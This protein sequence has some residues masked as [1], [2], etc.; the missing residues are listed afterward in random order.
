MEIGPQRRLDK[1]AR[2]VVIH[3]AW[4]AP[5][6][7][8]L[9]LFF[10]HNFAGF[11]R[12]EAMDTA[13]AARNISDGRGFS[14][15]FIR[16]LSLASQPI[17]ERM[18]DLCQPPLPPLLLGLVFTVFPAADS[19]VA[20]VS[21]FFFFLTVLL[22][23]VWARQ[24]FGLN[25]AI[26]SA[27]LLALNL[28]L[29]EITLFGA[30]VS[31]GAFLL[32]LLLF[33]SFRHSGNPKS[34]F[35]IGLLFGLSFL[36]EY[37]SLLLLP[38]LLWLLIAT[39]RERR[40]SH[41]G[42]FLLGSFL[43][44]APWAIRNYRLTGLP[45]SSLRWYSLAMFG[46]TYPGSSL[47]REI[48]PPEGGLLAFIF[49][50]P[51]EMAKKSLWALRSLY[52]SLPIVCGLYVVPFFI[53]GMLQPLE[54]ARLRNLRKC[55]YAALLLIAIG[56]A[57]TTGAAEWLSP[58]VPLVVIF[59]AFSFEK[60]LA[61][62]GL[63]ERRRILARAL[64][65]VAAALPLITNLLLPTARPVPRRGNLQQLAR[66]LPR[67]TLVATD[68]PWA[69]A[70]YANRT[71]VWL[72]NAPVKQGNQVI[73]PT[74]TE[75]FRALDGPKHRIGAIFLSSHLASLP[76]GEG[77][78]GWQGLRTAPR[79]FRLEAVLDGGE[80]LLTRDNKPVGNEGK[81]E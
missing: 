56:S 42:A 54:E 80:V 73:D 19:T 29:L 21:C 33:L 58:L 48:V 7:I 3:L 41:L 36:T 5:A 75:G 46:N 39:L 23:F 44:L 74:Q 26:L 22:A 71:A 31:L 79:G 51:G 64:L 1:A 25:V 62:A 17:A 15:D 34:S 45:W 11:Y 37:A 78:A 24:L 67:E 16:P 27:L 63:G 2:Q 72:P 12:A 43:V 28:A 32:T 69:V 8:L 10:Q 13:Q 20:L 14:T 81:G 47:L 55:L 77:L 52:T 60:L 18:P 59:S 70:W 61:S 6:L 40:W 30:L 38:A 76:A 57:V 49:S 50:H 53:A 9:A 68:I 65:L 35:G 66:S 4:F